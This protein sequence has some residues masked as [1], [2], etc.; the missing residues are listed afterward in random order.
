MVGKASV[1][2]CRSHYRSHYRNPTFFRGSAPK[3]LFPG[4][5]LVDVTWV[6]W[7]QS[8]PTVILLREW[9]S[10]SPPACASSQGYDAMKSTD[11]SSPAPFSILGS[12][13][14]LWWERSAWADG[15]HGC[16]C[17]R[18]HPFVHFKCTSWSV[19]TWC[20]HLGAWL[21]C[22]QNGRCISI[23]MIRGLISLLC[24]KEFCVPGL[25]WLKKHLWLW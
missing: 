3:A 1:Q 13:L 8:S 23:V 10:H 16:D 20:M 7:G 12:S 25:Q 11:L 21:Q 24:K 15:T 4:S 18:W 5:S 2:G 14:Y 19:L 6:F 22:K 9:V 17:D